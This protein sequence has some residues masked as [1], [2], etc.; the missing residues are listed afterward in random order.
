MPAKDT[1]HT[2]PPTALI[3]VPGTGSDADYVVR[4][5]GPAARMLGVELIA[6][7]PTDD[8]V[9]GYLR[10]FDH[11][12][13]TH[14]RVLVGGV[15]IGAAVALRWALGPAGASRC[16]GV[17][18]ALPAWS[19]D[20]DGSPAATSAR[21]TAE[22]LR[23]IGLSATVGAMAADSP[24]WLAAEL[25]RSWRAL[26][27]GLIDQLFAAAAHTA[28]DLADIAAL[29]APLAVTAAV[30]DPLHP[31]SVAEQ[32]CAAAPRADLTAVRLAEWGADPSLLGTSCA[33]GWLRMTGSAATPTESLHR[34]A[35]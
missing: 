19:G 23:D 2:A 5:F 34:R 8:L 6:P 24:K 32:W 28:P 13:E 4:A 20:P 33:R 1:G 14:R 9:N 27:P 7:D 16:A 17:L 22:S 10:H 25:T 21:L 15:S 30:D 11:A 29:R 18:A 3:A 35:R 12:A 31:Y 26:Y